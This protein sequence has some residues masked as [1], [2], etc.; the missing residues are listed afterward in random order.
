MAVDER[1]LDI[2][3]YAYMQEA[4]AAIFYEQL[5]ER[6]PLP[7][8]VKKLMDLARTEQHHQRCVEQWY[9]L[10]TGKK[11]MCTL[12]GGELEGKSTFDESPMTVSEVLHMAIQA[13]K[14]AEAQYRSWS[15]TAETEEQRDILE[16]M[17][18]QERDHVMV[19]TEERVGIEEAIQSLAGVTVPWDETDFLPEQV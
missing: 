15:K 6:T 12:T 11:L 5:A 8:V 14:R 7:S 2:L 16:L 13:E 19:L 9:S 18:D 17:A 3:R 10:A 1:I 4:K